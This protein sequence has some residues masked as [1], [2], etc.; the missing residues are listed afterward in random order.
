[1]LAHM[2]RALGRRTVSEYRRAL[3]RASFAGLFS[4]QGFGDAEVD[5]EVPLLVPKPEHWQTLSNAGRGMLRAAVRWA[6]AEAGDAETGVKLA[7]GITN[8]R[9]VRKAPKFPTRANVAAFEANARKLPKAER[10]CLLFLLAMGLRS[11]EFLRLERHEVEEALTTKALRF[12]RKG[13]K[14]T[15]LPCGHVV[16]HLRTLLGVRARVSP[17]VPVAP[18]DWMRVHEIFAEHPVAAYTALKR[19]VNRVGRGTGYD[20]TPHKL[21]HAFATEMVR[22]GAPIPVVQKALGHAHY[23]T[24][25]RRYVHVDGADLQTWMGKRSESKVQAPKRGRKAKGT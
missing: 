25:V 19:L 20:W 5:T 12:V 17:D 9:E 23:E 10:A 22:D 2:K 7:E 21:R 24:T 18:H 11:E 1:M 16:E 13:D 15:E 3:R 8:R 4:Q 6:Y 14:E